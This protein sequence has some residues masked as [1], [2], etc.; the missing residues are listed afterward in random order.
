MDVLPTRPPVLVRTR[1]GRAC[2]VTG[3]KSIADLAAK[4]SRRRSGGPEWDQKG[5]STPEGR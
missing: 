1:L 4:R 2:E 3:E 5:G